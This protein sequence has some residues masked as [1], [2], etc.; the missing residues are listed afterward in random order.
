ME[1]QRLLLET[2]QGRSPNTEKRMVRRKAEIERSTTVAK[3]G[4]VFLIDHGARLKPKSR[5]DYQQLMRK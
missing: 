3:L 4:E 5:E 1:A 2:K